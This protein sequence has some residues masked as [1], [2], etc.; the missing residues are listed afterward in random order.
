MNKCGRT[1]HPVACVCGRAIHVGIVTDICIIYI[2]Y[3]AYKVLYEIRV[4]CDVLLPLVIFLRVD[5]SI[6]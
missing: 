4:P 5:T 2:I 1:T 6:C 3:R